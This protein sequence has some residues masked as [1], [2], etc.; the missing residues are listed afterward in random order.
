MADLSAE[1]YTRSWTCKPF[2]LTSPVKQWP[3]H[4]KWSKKYLLQNYPEISVRAEAVDWPLKTYAD[5]MRNQTDESPLYLFDRG[6]AD[7]MSLE[8]G[9]IDS[10]QGAAY[11]APD[12][13]GRDL[14]AALGDQRPDHRWLI[15]GPERSGSTFHK[16]PNATSAWNAVLTGSKYWLMFPSSPTTPPPPGVILSSDSSEITSP[17]SIAEYMLVFHEMARATPGCKE[18]V[19]YAGEILHVPSG[20]FHLVL[21]LDESI[22]LTQNFVPEPKL[23]DVLKFLRDSPDQVSGFKEDV[24]DAYGLFVDRLRENYPDVLEKALA[25]L[26]ARD[27]GKSRKWEQLKKTS[28]TSED[29]GFS[30]GFGGGDED[31]DLVV[32]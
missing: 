13:F 29:G 25:K 28:E 14:F 31:D 15:F 9:S 12:C 27:E 8:V 17:V 22:A 20:W 11:W 1:E 32:P 4:G 5:Y 16:D 18:G 3:I 24:T 7:K 10:K 26:D 19:C 30:F 21:N 23:V 6:F 2:I